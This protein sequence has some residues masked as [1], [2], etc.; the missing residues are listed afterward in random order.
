MRVLIWLDLDLTYGLAVRK[1]KETL[2]EVEDLC[3]VPTA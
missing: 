3:L 2:A 1:G